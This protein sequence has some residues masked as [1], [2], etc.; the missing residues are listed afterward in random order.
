M[1]ENLHIE[2]RLGAE[3]HRPQDRVGVVRVNVVIRR[4]HELSGRP[5][6][7]DA[8]IEPA[9]DFRLRR[10]ALELQHQ[11]AISADQRHVHVDVQNALDADLVA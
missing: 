10:P 1:R 11:H 7:G 3:R 4:N 5:L 8:G 9:P 6:H 2:M